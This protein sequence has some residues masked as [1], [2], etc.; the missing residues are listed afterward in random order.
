[1]ATALTVPNIILYAKYSE[2]ASAI[3]IKRA[4]LNGGGIDL[5]LPLKIRSFR[6]S[7]EKQYN[8]Y[9]SDPTL[10]ATSNKL[11]AL[12]GIYGIMAQNKSGGGGG[13]ISPIT[14]I[15]TGVNFLEWIVID[16][17]VPI[18]TG[19]SILL[20]DGSGAYPDWRGYNLEFNRGNVLQDMLNSGAS[21]YSWDRTTGVFQCFP[22]AAVTEEFSLRPIPA[23][24]ATS[25]GA[26]V[27]A[28]STYTL[29]VNGQI[30]ITAGNLVTQIVLIS[31]TIQLGVLVGSTAGGSEYFGPVDLAV[32]TGIPL[33]I[34]LYPNSTSI[35]Y[36]TNTDALIVKLYPAQ[37]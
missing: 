37:S 6:V 22:I 19:G 3:A 16:S 18:S 23:N 30:S 8:A 25:S 12:C 1:M 15:S 4:G 13:S 33:T 36:F 7:I 10:I 9:P 31:T 20:L 32:N 17:G 27:T 5:Q 14:P 21:Y 34:S 28:F 24:A 2:Y 35:I 26:T 11:Y 29:G